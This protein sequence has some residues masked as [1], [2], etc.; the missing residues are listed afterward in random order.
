MRREVS[1]SLFSNIQET[2]KYIEQQTQKLRTG[3]LDDDT[4]N[5]LAGLDESQLPGRIESL[6]KGETDAK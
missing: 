5:A 1:V 6:L 2:I 4:S 3:G